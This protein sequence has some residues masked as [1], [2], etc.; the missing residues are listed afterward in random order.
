MGLI[1]LC[2]CVSF[3]RC[4]RL[5]GARG[6]KVSSGSDATRADLCREEEVV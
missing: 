1:I 4:I 3:R 2:C 6:S 5:G